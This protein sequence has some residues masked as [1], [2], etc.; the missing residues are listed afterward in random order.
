MAALDALFDPQSIAVIGASSDPN[1]LGGRPIDFCKRGGF[2]RPIYPI[3][4]N[5]TEVQGLRSYPS[6]DAVPGPVDLA[7][8]AVPAQVAPA[9]VDAALAKGVRA[10]I[11][12]TAGFGEVDAAGLA[13]QE[14]MAARCRAAG[15][16]MLG[17]NCLGAMNVALGFICT[18]AT[19]LDNAWPTPGRVSVVSQSG[20]FG[21]YSYGLAAERGI[22]FAKWITTG[23]EADVDV[24]RALDWLADD[25]DTA[26]IMAYI[27]G[28]RDGDALRRALCKAA[29][30]KKPV[31]LLK[32]GESALGAQAAAS[33]TGSLAGDDAV[34]DAMLRACGAYRAR[35]VDEL[36]DV[37]YACANGVYPRGAKVGVMTVSGG[38]GVLMADAGAALGLELTPMPEAAQAEIKSI[39]PYASAL[40]PIDVTAQLLNVSHE[41]GRFLDII[42]DAGGYDTV[43]VFMQQMGKTPKHFALYREPIMA[44][45]KRHPATLH[46]LCGGY[47]N[48]ARAEVEAE[49]F[50]VFEDPKRAMTA[51]AALAHFARTFAAP[52]APP[53]LAP[54]ASE[55]LPAGALD[56]AAAKA[57]L[58]RAGIP[59]PPERIARDRAGAIAAAEAIGYPVVLKV[60]SPDIAH[61]SDAGGVALDLRD[62][63][64]VG[65][66]WDA[67]MGRV[68]A[69]AP[70][71][72]VDGALVAKMVTG[73]VE[74]VLG[75]VRDPVFGP[76][77]MFGLGG[78]F[79]EIFR[80]VTFRP[81][82]VS[83]D[84]ALAM[85]R[86]I[87]GFALLDG[88]RGRPKADLGVI[89]DAL[90]AL[91]GFGSA[92]RDTVRGIDINPFIA[93]AS[94]GCAV[95]A[96][97]DRE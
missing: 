55:P 84:E 81:A 60:L 29:R 18:F 62:A 64:A 30:N 7:V 86:E 38:M 19:V 67:V 50:V 59:F 27:E 42:Q 39:I 8:I 76:V 66:A 69:A 32:A 10:I 54:E 78:V 85:I 9:A 53:E 37:V 83:R 49:G 6:L 95:D 74:T 77:V 2:P 25:P 61:K 51:I 21:S 22:G 26:V 13:A 56:E 40:N 73:G 47:S 48:E 89:A 34:W 82:P 36:V 23:N 33:H 65:E 88:A 4:P 3:N 28:C 11:M 63:R 96:L 72:R 1:R 44:Q 91:G 20:A 87:R 45:R 70:R 17:P 12:F 15:V 97:I 58:A 46:V 93:L 43:V 92:H 90:V 57:I 68:K 79:V 31:V 75:L 52:P 35:T 5:Q 94:G 71:A 80:D 16:P 14:A 41:F 24:P